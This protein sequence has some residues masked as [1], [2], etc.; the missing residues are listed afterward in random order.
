MIENCDPNKG[1]ARVATDWIGDRPL[2]FHYYRY[3]RIFIIF[4]ARNTGLFDIAVTCQLV[5]QDRTHQGARR[6]IS[7]KGHLPKRGIRAGRAKAV[8]ASEANCAEF[9]AD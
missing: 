1:L 6:R 3:P 8:R 5:F 7:N 2:R 4:C 9:L